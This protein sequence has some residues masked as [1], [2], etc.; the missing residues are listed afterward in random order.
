MITLLYASLLGILVIF[1]A[2]KTGMTRLKEN[3]LLGDGNSSSMLQ[4]IRAHGNLI[5]YLP[6]F[7]IL[8]GLIEMQ[9]VAAWQLHTV[10]SIFFVGRILHAYGMYIS[11]E[12][13]PFRMAGII[14]TWISIL[15]LSISGITLYISAL[16]VI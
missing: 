10:G 11:S 12:S 2:Y 1:L 5:E 4:A 15:A 6:I 8:L 7:L 13:T 16:G 3:N 9:N 14:F